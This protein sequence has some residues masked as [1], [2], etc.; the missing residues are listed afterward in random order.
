MAE[1]QCSPRNRVAEQAPGRASHVVSC[2]AFVLSGDATR[3]FRGCRVSSIS[4]LPPKG[5]ARRKRVVLALPPPRVG[6][7]PSPPAP[8]HQIGRRG[9]ENVR[10]VPRFSEGSRVSVAAGL[11]VTDPRTA[12]AISERSTPS[13]GDRRGSRNGWVE[14]P[15][16]RK[17][18]LGEQRIA[19]CG[20]R[21]VENKIPGSGSVSDENKRCAEEVLARTAAVQA[22]NSGKESRVALASISAN[23]I[24]YPLRG[25]GP[26]AIGPIPD[27]LRSADCRSPPAPRPRDRAIRR[28]GCAAASASSPRQARRARRPRLP[29]ASPPAPR[30]ARTRRHRR[31]IAPACS[32]GIGTA[33]TSRARPL[34]CARN[35]AGVLGRQGAADQDQRP[36]RRLLEIRHRLGEPRA[37]RLRCARRRAR[38]R[39]RRARGRPAGR[40]CSRCSRAG[41]C[42]SSRPRSKAATRQIGRDRAQ[43]RRSRW[44]RCR[45]D[46]GRASRGSGRSSRPCS[47]SIDQPARSRRARKIAARRRA[48][49]RRARSPRRSITASA[50]SSCAATIAGAP[51]L[52]MPA[53][54]KA[55]LSIVAPRNSGWSIDTGVMTVASRARRSHWSRRSAR[56]GRLRAADSRPG[57][58]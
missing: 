43:R 55:I 48:A 30:G 54:S 44:R 14:P 28:S 29:D 13:R 21:S 47:S 51:G 24:L 41:H 9:D 31:P 42:A 53:F 46:A 39:R 11:I 8:P 45:T 12:A 49:A 34:K 15:V 22:W 17:S 5:G 2:R 7:A 23:F 35:A 26:L 38:F 50:S 25:R 3:R 36:R 27:P 1:Q 19:P 6:G 40:I 10:Q 32:P 4:R 58:R 33:T 56:Q 57:S 16:E 52:M 18:L 37:R 20:S